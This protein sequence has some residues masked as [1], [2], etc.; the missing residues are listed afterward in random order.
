MIRHP[1]RELR[2][3]SHWS[4]FRPQPDGWFTVHFVTVPSDVSSGIMKIERILCEALPNRLRSKRARTASVGAE[5]EPEG[6]ALEESQS[7]WRF[8]WNLV[9]DQVR[10]GIVARQSERGT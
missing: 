5:R 3:H 7:S 10:D 8:I 1:P 9:R 2:S 4:C 6:R